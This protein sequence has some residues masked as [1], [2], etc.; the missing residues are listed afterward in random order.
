MYGRHLGHQRVGSGA[1]RLPK[2]HVLWKQPLQRPRDQKDQIEL[3][4]SQV[5]RPG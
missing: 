5:D 1:L 2:E 3:G 4:E